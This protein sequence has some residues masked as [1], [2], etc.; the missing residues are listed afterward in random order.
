MRL[1]GRNDLFLLLGLTAALF[2]IF[3]RPLARA[4]DWAREIDRSWG[5]QLVPGLVILA[6]VFTFHQVRKRH[7][8]RVQALAS[9][10]T[11]RLATERVERL[12]TF[13]KALGEALDHAAIGRVVRDYLPNL[14][15][16][17][18]AWAMAL[19]SGRMAPS[20]RRRRPVLDRM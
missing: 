20:R 4:L 14:A 3:S 2:A 10:A 8:M 7:E 9:T 18:G 5:L 1:I 15:E 6:V 19:S 12:V 13:G 11:A 16:G 17:R